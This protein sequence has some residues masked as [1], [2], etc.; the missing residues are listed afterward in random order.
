M[1]CRVSAKS[2]GEKGGQ[3]GS[4]FLVSLGGKESKDDKRVIAVKERN[5]LESQ[6][7]ESL[8]GSPSENNTQ[9]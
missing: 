3:T 6:G 5:L 7:L 1:K 8:T 9:R 4:S 2:E